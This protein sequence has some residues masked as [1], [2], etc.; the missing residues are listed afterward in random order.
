VP[1]HALLSRARLVGVAALVVAATCVASA[2]GARAAAVSPASLTAHERQVLYDLYAEDTAIARARSAADRATARAADLDRELAHA[3]LEAS[4]A[5][6]ALHSAQSRLALRLAA[7]YREGSP[8]D[9]VEIF[10]GARSLSSAIDQVKLWHTATRMDQSVIIQ[11][12]L[13]RAR[14]RTATRSL[15]SARATA[16]TQ[17]DALIVQLRELEQARAA[18][19]AL[20]ASLRREAR[21]GQAR[22][23]ARRRIVVL[24]HRAQRATR[25]STA[26][27]PSPPSDEPTP[28]V[29][30]T[31]PAPPAPA[32]P[33]G[34]LTVG[35][36]AY[37]LPG[38]TATGLPVGQGVCAVDPSVIP[39]GTRF[40]VP[41]YGSCLAAD[42]GPAIVG[43]RIDVWVATEAAAVA[44]GRRD[45][46]ITF[47]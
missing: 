23:A 41:G 37:A 3:R 39:L 14:Y 35:S 31:S 22:A 8:P 32:H 16:Q 25:R 6:R 11:T 18:K 47:P 15:A 10:L 43:N 26:I 2:N 21:A 30:L 42:T 28:Q 34:S 19:A 36:T 44:W 1:P 5:R 7:W 13:A 12:T 9:A 24:V 46:T 27:A 29:Q 40:D 38:S 17:H 45:V 4:L 33:G 20:L